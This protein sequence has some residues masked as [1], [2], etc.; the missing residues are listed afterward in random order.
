WRPD[1]LR[2]KFYQVRQA[3]CKNL[4][5]AVSQRL[6]LEKAGVDVNTAP[7]KI[8]WFKVKLLPKAVLEALESV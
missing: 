2:K 6:N 8:V 1:Y 7:A 5:L 3:E 4:I